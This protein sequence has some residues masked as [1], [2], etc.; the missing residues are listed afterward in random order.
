M[1]GRTVFGIIGWGLIALTVVGFLL[2]ALLQVETGGWYR[3]YKYQYVTY[4]GALAT[5]VIVGI[6]GVIG[7]YYW[8]KRVMSTAGGEAVCP[9][10]SKPA[11]QQ[12]QFIRAT[13]IRDGRRAPD[14]WSY[15]WCSACEARFKQRP[16]GGFTQPTS[17]EWSQYCSHHGPIHK[18]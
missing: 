16:G 13:I 15:F 11:L 5:L 2:R 7:L 3:T 6:V 18:S 14:S 12:V 8:I 1:K 9:S 10:C 17:E 4:L